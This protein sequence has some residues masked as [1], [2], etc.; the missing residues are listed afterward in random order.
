M[1]HMSLFPLILFLFLFLFVPIRSVQFLSLLII[2]FY[3]VSFLLSRYMKASIAVRREKETQFCPNRSEEFLQFTVSN[4]GIFPLSDIIIQDSANGCYS[5]KTGSFLVDLPG[6][7]SSLFSCPLITSRRGL[8]R[9]GPIKV[10][11]TDPLNL[12]PWELVFYLYS[13]V[14]VY[15]AGHNLT[16]TFLDGERGGSLKSNLLFHE[17]PTQLKGIR[18]YRPG[19]SLK[20]VNWKVSARTGQLKIMEF[21]RRFSAPLLVLLDLT[22]S[23]YPLKHRHIFLERAIE[24]AVS[25]CIS[26]NN[27][28]RVSLFW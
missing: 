1:N 16:L 10:K 19:D 4:R 27:A 17:D 21:S 18:D 25:L 11:G 23:R 8:F 15:P 26:Y 5:E 3:L 28:G 24:A 13:S 22:V 12:F 9:A 6:R 14:V 20:K 7:S 2:L